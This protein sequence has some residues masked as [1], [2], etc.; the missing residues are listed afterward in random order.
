[1][2]RHLTTPCLNTRQAS[3]A[4]S[5]PAE[6]AETAGVAVVIEGLTKSYAGAGGATPALDQMDAKIPAGRITVL[7]GPDGA[8]KTTLLRLLA[9]LI[10][11][12]SGVITFSNGITQDSV[13]IGYMPQRF[14][15]YDDLTVTENLRLYAA[16]FGITPATRTPRID[17][18]IG[19]VGLAHACQRR[20]GRL[21]GG[22]RQKLALAA[23]LLR[24]QDLLLLDEPTIGMDP[25][26]RREM[27]D[28][29]ESEG[30]THGTT[31]VMTTNLP[32]EAQRSSS[33]ILM[34]AGKALPPGFGV[35][36]EEGLTMAVPVLPAL[37][38]PS[39][40]RRLSSLQAR[41]ST[42]SPPP[43]PVILLEGVSRRFG[44]FW[45]VRG[46]S[47]AIGRG[48]IF[49]LLG[50][51]GAGKSTLIR[52]LCGL[53]APTAGS[54]RVAGVDVCSSTLE[55][56]AHIGYVPQ[57]FALYGS[58]T[59]RQNL[60]LFATAYN[61]ARARQRTVINQS[62]QDF[63][64]ADFESRNTN[65]LSKSARQRLAIAC[66]LLH[67]PD[68]LVL[69][70]PTSGTDADARATLW[71][72]ID[73]LTL[74]GTTILL[75]THDMSEADRCDR[76]AIMNDGEVLAYGTPLA[77]CRAYTDADQPLSNMEQVFIARLT[78]ARQGQD[79]A[80]EAVILATPEI[81]PH[82][83]PRVA[84][85]VRKEFLQILRDP[86]SVILALFMPL[87][88]L[89]L[90]GFGVS[91]DPRSVPL[92]LVLD[93]PNAVSESLA[94]AF[95]HSPYFETRVL[96]DM[97]TAMKD[98]S[99]HRVLGVLRIHPIS[100]RDLLGGNT[101]TV[102]LLLNGVDANT[103]RLAES[104]VHGA[105][106]QWNVNWITETE[107][108]TAPPI[109]LQPLVWFNR[110]TL[111]NWFLVPG[112]FGIIMAL[113]GTLLSALA[114]AREW[115]RGSLENLFATPVRPKEM[116]MGKLLPYTAIGFTSSCLAIAI[117]AAVFGVPMH[118]PLVMILGLMLL[119]LLV[120]VGFGIVIANRTRNQFA[121]AVLAILGSFMP[122]F[123][124]AGFIFDIHSM[125]VWLS[126]VTFAVPARYVVSGLRTL[127]LVGTAPRATLWD[128]LPLAGFGLF[129]LAMSFRTTKWRPD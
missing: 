68:I 80:P 124:L 45:A 91:L 78:E 119:F 102:Q 128:F 54:I 70:E 44:S 120:S 112:L 1:M 73:E 5:A 93:R 110:N 118:A 57:K 25:L 116:V 103:A 24:P 31:I 15:L 74:R 62:L 59:V 77:L 17:G 99:A 69:D 108:R 89:L 37:S 63:K 2:L 72:I 125:P 115:E 43:A 107:N 85:L 28:F 61:V 122:A 83:R 52:M 10:K 4:E 104:Y 90:F 109:F 18:I 101:G 21:S 105:L 39:P 86:S 12:D 114:T 47:L 111:S 49:G 40:L 23:V 96:P 117:A 42:V 19:R 92:A 71:N 30:A 46:V 9:G 126:Y 67:A 106:S 60:E 26:A 8:G 3:A 127:L 123:L 36:E 11:P 20:A 55:A 7:L 95:G 64:L 50:A 98:L 35:S 129:F 97:Q 34:A 100:V 48:E 79:N 113:T 65:A 75:S 38:Y 27:W 6:L 58:L 51:N 56:R 88:L 41:S 33:V 14:G 66:A 29:L 94:G 22:M 82:P 84:G 13:K 81:S 121:A 53:I 16:L 76:V 32:Q 87:F